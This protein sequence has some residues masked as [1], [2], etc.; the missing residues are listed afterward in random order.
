MNDHAPRA[1][2][3]R[4]LI[5]LSPLPTPRGIPRQ[6]KCDRPPIQQQASL[7]IHIVAPELLPPKEPL[8]IARDIFQLLT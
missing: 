4:S 6:T 7:T 5:N 3:G 2:G 1:S 8:D